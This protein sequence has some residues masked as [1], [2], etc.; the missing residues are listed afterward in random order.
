MI[1]AI[2][3]FYGDDYLY[4]SDSELEAMIKG[5]EPFSSVDL[6]LVSHVH[7]DHFDAASVSRFLEEHPETLLISSAQTIDSLNLYAAAN[8]RSR[9]S[10][11]DHRQDR[12]TEFDDAGVALTVLGIKHGS[13]R[14]NWVQNL[15]H[16]VTINGVKLLH[17]GDASLDLRRF[18]GLDLV[19]EN[20]DIAIIPYW[21][22][23]ER[24]KMDNMIGAE[25]YILTHISPREDYTSRSWEKEHPDVRMFIEKGEVYTY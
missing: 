3:K 8:V 6:L 18:E 4:P 22:I 9:L 25:S 10:I 14:F 17:V 11:A 12:R 7:G 21:Y 23:Y 24:E 16:I 13:K 15:G 2:H 19:E 1:D 5:T 20:I